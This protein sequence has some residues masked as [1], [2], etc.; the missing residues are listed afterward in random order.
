MTGSMAAC[1]Q[2][3]CWRSWEFYVLILSSQEEIRIP[4]WAELEHRRPQSPAP[5]MIHFLSQNH[6]Y[7]NKAI[8]VAQAFKHM[9]LWVPRLFKSPQH[10]KLLLRM[11]TISVI[12]LYLHWFCSLLSLLLIVESWWFTVWSWWC[13]PALHCS[14][15]PLTKLILLCDLTIEA[16]L[17]HLYIKYSFKHL[18]QCWREV[19]CS[20]Y[21]FAFVTC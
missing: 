11:L 2:T 16:I 1:R 6:T 10:L 14:S 3:C 8:P 19:W 18:L 12:F 7:S 17:L 9:N 4:H 21:M 15:F 5:T 13:F 20:F